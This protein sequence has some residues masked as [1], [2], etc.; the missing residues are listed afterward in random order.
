VDQKLLD[1]CLAVRNYFAGGSSCK[2]L[3]W[4]S[5]VCVCL[6]DRISPEPHAPSLPNFCACCL[7]PWLGPP[8]TR[9]W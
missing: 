2:V 9:S 7:C 1:K 5:H 4:V 3:W 8:L 6:S